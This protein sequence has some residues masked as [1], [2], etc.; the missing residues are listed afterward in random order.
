MLDNAASYKTAVMGKRRRRLS[1][2]GLCL[3]YLP[4]YSPALNRIE[5]LWEH[6]KY[7]WRRFHGVNVRCTAR[8]V[9]AKFF[10]VRKKPRMHFLVRSWLFLW[11]E[12]AIAAKYVRQCCKR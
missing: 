10:V 5:I 2:K 11:F 4:P 8:L 12:G 9:K 3:Y 1:K 6:T 7:F